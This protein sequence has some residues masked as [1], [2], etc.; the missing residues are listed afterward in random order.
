MNTQV[1]HLVVMAS[2][3]DEGVQWCERTLGIT[4]GPG[5]AHPLLGTHNRL[6]KIAAP[7]YA[8]A[9][10]EIIA[11]DP[12]ATPQRA[13]PL[14]R[15]FD[16]DD[17]A[18]RAR[19]AAHGPQLAHWVA[20]TAD[21]HAA[22]SAWQ[23]LGIERGAPLPASRMTPHGLL[24]WQ[25][26]VRDDGQRLFD[27][28]LP[29]LIQWGSQH[30]AHRIADSALALRSLRLRHPEAAALTRAL[31]AAGVD[32][33]AVRVEAGAPALMALLDTPRGPVTLGD[34]G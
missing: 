17:A 32:S 23:A 16:F 34:D 24:E 11:I 22:V 6:L 5:G 29:T 20:R 12:G 7:G 4:P 30:P 25:I 19:L 2:R 26:T 9:Y 18:L 3:L 1:D 28:C 8:D 13:S 21:V 14:K 15:W 31:A 33:A 10:L 27:G